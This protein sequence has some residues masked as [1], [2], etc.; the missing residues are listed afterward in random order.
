MWTC[1]LTGKNYLTYE[2]AL[3]SEKKA[4]EVV[5]KFPEELVAPVLHDVQFSKSYIFLA[6]LSIWNS[7]GVFSTRNNP[8]WY[9]Y[10]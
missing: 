3:V 10:L 8:S 2:E 6:F 5:Q 4:A 1:K 9:V 7:V